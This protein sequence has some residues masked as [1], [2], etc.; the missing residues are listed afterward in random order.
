MSRR[1]STT[2]ETIVNDEVSVVW[3]V[4]ANVFTIGGL[5]ID[6]KNALLLSAFITLMMADFL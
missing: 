2:I 3:D 5:H 1:E 4:D 6:G